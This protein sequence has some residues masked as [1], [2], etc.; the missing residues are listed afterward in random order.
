MKRTMAH[1][2]SLAAAS[3]PFAFASI[4][5]LQTGWDFRYFLIAAAGLIG[6]AATVAIGRAYASDWTTVTMALVAFVT[7][8]L[9]S[10]L[11]AM[12]IGTRESTNS[13]ATVLVVSWSSPS[14]A[15]QR[16]N[17]TNT[18]PKRSGNAMSPRVPMN[19]S[20]ASPSAPSAA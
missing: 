10:V 17:P 1:A 6:A 7:A 14:Q 12:A 2:L 8:A 20:R 19:V 3:L 4:R 13:R 9:L 5:A 16:A 18:S 15:I 11:G